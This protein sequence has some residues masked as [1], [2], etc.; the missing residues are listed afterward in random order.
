MSGGRGQSVVTISSPPWQRSAIYLLVFPPSQ[1]RSGTFANSCSWWTDAVLIWNCYK[2]ERCAYL[3]RS[4]I[5]GTQRISTRHWGFHIQNLVKDITSTM[6][7]WWSRVQLEITCMQWLQMKALRCRGQLT[8]MEKGVQR[9]QYRFEDIRLQNEHR[10]KPMDFL[11]MEQEGSVARSV[12]VM[13]SEGK[14]TSD[15]IF[16]SDVLGTS[17]DIWKG[18][19]GPIAT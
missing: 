14:H 9:H 4:E 18:F 16:A 2:V 17:T 15:K 7:C 1:Q 6:R 3:L 5:E 10:W 11:S 8:W 13:K 19:T 12:A